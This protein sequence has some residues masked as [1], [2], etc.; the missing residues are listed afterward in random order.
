MKIKSLA[1]FLL[2]YLTTSLLPS[3]AQATRPISGQTIEF[4]SIGTNASALV[5]HANGGTAGRTYWISIQT[6][7]DA[8]AQDPNSF[9]MVFDP[10]ADALVEGKTPEFS[11]SIQDTDPVDAAT[12]PTAVKV[13]FFL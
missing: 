6:T 3:T 12:A 2:L 9:C 1:L 7:A 13:A 8:S 4:A 5:D 10:D 11:V